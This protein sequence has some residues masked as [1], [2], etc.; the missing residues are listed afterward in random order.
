MIHSYDATPS[1]SLHSLCRL[2]QMAD[3]AFPVGGFA[4]SNG[5]EAAVAEGV[6]RDALTL[7]DFTR[8]LVRVAAGCDCVAM[9]HAYRAATEGYLDQ[10]VVSDS[11]LLSFK[12]SAEARSMTLKM[13]RRLTDLLLDTSPTPVPHIVRQWH[14]W[15]HSDHSVGTY[16]I[17]QAVAAVVWGVGEEELFV[18]HLYGVASSVL[19]AAL[20]LMRITHVETQQIALRL[21]PLV[22][23]LYAN[24]RHR[25]LEDMCSFAPML[26]VA[27][28]LHEKGT[29]RMFMS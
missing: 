12:I 24:N 6:V 15:V 21:A 29:R 20:R 9:L 19:G 16:P 3:S 25:T 13:G 27:T 1:P 26:D 18:G 28:S 7:G 4:F 11:H 8:G 14:H 22:E 2:V 23:E 10:L 5:L 17:A